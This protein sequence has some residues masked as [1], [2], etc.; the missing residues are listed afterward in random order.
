MPLQ[1]MPEPEEHEMALV[2]TVPDGGEEEWFCPECG[3]RFLMEWPP[4]FHRSI[5]E[6]GNENAIHVGHKGDLSFQGGRGNGAS[7]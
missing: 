1:S 5:L 7:N 4:H 2:G 3:R 6:P